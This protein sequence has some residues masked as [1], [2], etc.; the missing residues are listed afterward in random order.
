MRNGVRQVIDLGA[1]QLAPN[2][3]GGDLT[4]DVRCHVD[5][6]HKRPRTHPILLHPDWSVDTGHDLEAERF[7]VAFGGYLSCLDLVDKVIPAVRTY[8]QRQLR[9]VLPEISLGV[10][11]RWTVTNR[12]DGCCA[13]FTSYA[14]PQEAANHYRSP[15]HVAADVGNARMSTVRTVGKQVLWA[16]GA[17]DP[18]ML[19]GAARALV[20]TCVKTRAEL[21]LLWDAGLTPEMIELVHDGAGRPLPANYYLGVLSKRPDLKW[22]HA[23]AAKTPDRDVHEWLA[24]TETDSDR[25]NPTRRG[26]WLA[27]GVSFRDVTVFGET[28][29]TPADVQLL[30]D[31]TRKTTTAA[32]ALLANWVRAGC[33]PSIPA[34]AAVCRMSDCGPGVVTRTAVDVVSDLTGLKGPREHFAFALTLCG[35]PSLAA[36]VIH[37][38]NSLEPVDLLRGLQEWELAR[39][40][41]R[42]VVA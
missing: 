15:R 38:T 23:T 6:Q 26:E 36:H 19:P 9:L 16:H 10:G 11:A 7:T 27:L 32:A 3:R 41:R 24:W 42:H 40:S 2:A 13:G 18:V 37:A 20:G 12:V 14:T 21:E 5:P 22:V 33:L 35:A 34:L 25:D 31:E 39:Q 4:L 1:E 29:Y 28:A 17:G 30:A 8:A